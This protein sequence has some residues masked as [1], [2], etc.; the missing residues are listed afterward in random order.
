MATNIGPKIGIEGESEYRSAINN[1][2]QQQKTLNS[3]MQKTAAAFSKDTDAKKKNAAQIETLNKLI[4]NQKDRVSQLQTMYEKSV[5]K[6]G[7]NATATLKWK[8]ALNEAEAELAKLENQLKSMSGPT[9]FAEQME[10]AGKRLADV[11]KKMETVGTN[12]TK[13]ITGPIAAIGTA[14]IAAFKDVDKGL[15]TIITKTG[16]TG[17][18]LDEMKKSM[19]NLASTIPTT[20]ESAGAAIGEVNTRFGLTGKQ[21]EETAGLFL[22]FAKINNTDVSTSIDNVQKAMAA[23]NIDASETARVLDILNKVGQNTGVSVDTLTAGLIQNGT[24][25]E[26][27]GLS[28][29]QAVTFM[30]QLEKSGANSETVMQGLRKALKNAAKD[31]VPLE[32]ALAELQNTIENG[33]GSMDG[34][35]AAYD[36]FG[37][38][39]DQI[40]GAI[41]NGTLDFRNLAIAVEDAGGSV[42]DTFTATLDPLDQLKTTMNALKVTGAEL[43]NSIL[44]LVAPMIEQL[45]ENAR[46]L[47]EW[48]TSLDSGTQQNIVR[49]GAFVASVGPVITILGKTTSTIGSVMTAGSSLITT[50]QSMGGMAGMMGQAVAFLSSPFGIAVAAIG[51]AVAAGVILY[52]NWDTIKEKASALFSTISSV[53]S[54]IGTKIS[55]VMNTAA[56]TVSSAISRIKGLFNFSWSLPRLQLPHFSWT[57][58]DLGHGISLPHISVSWYKKAYS[59]ALMFSSPTVIPTA[60][61]FKGFGDGAGNE[62][63]IGENH[64]MQTIRAAVGGSGAGNQI[65]ITVNP[66]AGMDEEELAD[67]VAEKLTEQIKSNQEIFA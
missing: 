15:D 16:A 26:E 57:W 28:L 21:L 55:S 64:L 30:G 35:T 41:R 66:S 29:E 12:M 65:Y 58:S 40:Y 22:E 8:Q 17:E 34:L 2:I 49:M 38:S 67:L 24:A 60:A 51:G 19:E 23:Y 50:F 25:F 61:G 18:S 7:E 31:G 39:G 46:K 37:K 20:F 36:M 56:N 3:E 4:A 54:N 11:G 52:K 53:F 6:N 13:Y 63:V 5:Q 33:T 43:G 62:I 27:L 14:S 44:T 47:A 1:I 48:F 9:T 59:N 32:Q 10:A 42:H 45:A